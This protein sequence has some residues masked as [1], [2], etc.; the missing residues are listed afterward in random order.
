LRR[1]DLVD[2]YIDRAYSNATKR[3][4]ASDMAQFRA[5]CIENDLWHETPDDEMVGRYLAAHARTLSPATLNRRVA[6]ISQFCRESGLPWSWSSKYVRDVL[7]GIKKESNRSEVKS[8]ALGPDEIKRMVACVD[9]TLRGQR[10][11]A[12]LLVGYAGALRRSELVAIEVEHIV[13]DGQE[14]K[15]LIQRSKEDQIGEGAVIRLTR[16]SRPDAC[17]IHALEGWL[18]NSGIRSGAVFRKIDQWR[19]ISPSGL[20]PDAVRQIMQRLA[21]LAGLE[22]P[23]GERLSPHSLRAGFVT[24]A[25]AFGASLDLMMLV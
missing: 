24:A 2:F 17:P 21:A 18:N 13:F 10:D 3:A 19:N 20:H 25:F 5:W 4:Y 23:P 22:P 11:R 8:A 9:G 15:I 6:A 12:L 1:D 14:I 7:R 16:A